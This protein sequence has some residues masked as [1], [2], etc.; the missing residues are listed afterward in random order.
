MV[1]KSIAALV[2]GVALAFGSAQAGAAELMVFATGSM[3]EPLKELGEE[4]GRANGHTLSF[5]AAPTGAVM[6]KLGA[7]DRADVIVISAD[8]AD[9]LRKE[10][11]IVDG[12]RVDV[13]RSL[14]GVGIKAGAPAPDI[15]TPEA[16]KKTVL[17]ARS[18]SY[19]DP[20]LGSASGIYVE[21]LFAQL[22]I[23]DEAKKKAVIKP[24]GLDVT[25]AVA[26][27]EVE[28][29]LTFISEMVSNKG[30]RVVGPFPEAIQSPTLYTGAV[31]STSANAAA[32]RAYLA[33]LTTPEARAK[34]KAAGVDPVA[35]PN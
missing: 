5:F 20:A 25:N 3:V 15:S 1:T 23:A 29:A 35:A 30:V 34:L 24:I 2:V 33:F 26:K 7:G 17:A 10:G 19:S 8:A 6:A 28:L 31:S 32:A 12:S 16:F 4:F 18:V 11:R 13:A 21:K 14:F 27:G 9:T 22:G